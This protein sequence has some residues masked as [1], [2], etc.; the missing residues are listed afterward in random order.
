MSVS[1]ISINC[2]LFEEIVADLD[3]AEVLPSALRESALAHAE[4]CPKCGLLLTES[5]SLDMNLRAL[6]GSARAETAAPRIESLLL[7]E[8][9]ENR[10]GKRAR[11]ISW[12]LAA[13]GVAAAF[14]LA[15]SLY[16][17]GRIPTKHGSPEH[18][19]NATNRTLVT[20]APA[21]PAS[22][23]PAKLSAAANK[24]ETAPAAG[25]PQQASLHQA[26]T[27]IPAEA[28]EAAFI[29]LP[30]ADSTSRMEGGE[31]VRVIL[32][33]EALESLGV[34]TLYAGSSG[35]VSADLLLDEDGTPEAI[36]LVAQT[37]T[38]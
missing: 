1:K 20:P 7:K 25:T 27:P 26:A 11:K 3:R 4:V 35:D 38:N 14:A 33:P 36:R 31:V 24:T 32:T 13:L 12:Q 8:F 2:H 17:T 21:S 6:A 22:S 30:Y 18:V 9:R 15:A 23:S 5:E 34:R 10:D 19:A 29:P 37:E 16:L 28:E